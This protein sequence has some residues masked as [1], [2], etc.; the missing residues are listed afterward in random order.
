MAG[1]VDT[2]QTLQAQYSAALQQALTPRLQ[3]QLQQQAAAQNQVTLVQSQWFPWSDMRKVQNAIAQQNFQYALS[4]ASAV[5]Q[6]YMQAVTRPTETAARIAALEAENAE[7]RKS[8]R[9]SLE[10][11]ADIGCDVYGYPIRADDKPID[12][13]KMP[14]DTA[15][16][17]AYEAASDILNGRV[18][19]PGR[20]MLRDALDRAPADP[21]TFPG[22]ALG[23]HRQ[24]MGLV[25][26][27]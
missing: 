13:P 26:P 12:R 7:L 8:I 21:K 18:T 20:D 11:A 4:T 16:D 17:R 14:R 10:G 23:M 24:Q 22:K 3:S 19:K 25:V 15:H 5:S 2:K 1:G 27:R 9:Q 6:D